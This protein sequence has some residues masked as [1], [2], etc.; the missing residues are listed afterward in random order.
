M[1][2][3]IYIVSFSM[4]ILS[5]FSCK[6]KTE[7]S[8]PKEVE[9]MLE[10]V[11]EQAKSATTQTKIYTIKSCYIKFKNNVSGQEMIREWWFDDFGNKQF[12]DNYMIIMDTK[13]GSQSIITDGYKYDWN[14]DETS[15]RK[16][17]YKL[18]ATTDYENVSAKDIERYG[19]EKHG[20]EDI[21]GKKCLKVTMKKP[22]EATTWIWN[23]TPLKTISK[24][25][26]NEVIIEAIEI[27]E[28]KVDDHLFELP[29]E[30]SFTESL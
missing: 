21:L 5:V 28:G 8:M 18:Y 24:Y 15:G 26:G 30:V 20:Y 29:S 19:I 23:G 11:E 10:E 14:Y 22:A 2:K 9:N 6:S 12:E 3:L 13:T 17:K 4:I 16:T 27:R 25:A 7:K 1:K